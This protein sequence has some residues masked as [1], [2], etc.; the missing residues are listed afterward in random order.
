MNWL[1]KHILSLDKGITKKESGTT[2]SVYYNN[3]YIRIRVSS[4]LPKSIYDCDVYVFKSLN[5]NM[6]LVIVK[7]TGV[8]MNFRLKELKYFLTSFYLMNKATKVA[9]KNLN[10]VKEKKDDLVLLNKTNTPN[11][12]DDF[13]ITHKRVEK[14]LSKF[15]PRQYNVAKHYYVSQKLRGEKF[16]N[17]LNSLNEIGISAKNLHQHFKNFL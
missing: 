7:K 12:W 16:I 9:K 14:R 8:L 2:D 1:E 11:V 15:T 4:H 10:E 6:Y 17:A 5:D 13:I 3:K